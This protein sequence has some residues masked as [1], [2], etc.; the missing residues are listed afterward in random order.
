MIVLPRFAALFASSGSTLPTSTALVLGLSNALR[1]N[2]TVVVLAVVVVAAI[3]AW[4]AT[5]PDA[6][7][8][9]SRI[10]ISTPIVSPFYR[11]VLAARAARVI[12]ILLGGGAPL[13]QALDDA[14][15]SLDDPSARQEILRVRSRVREG[16]SAAAAFAEGTLFPDVLS[17]LIA[18]GEESSQLEAFFTKAADLFEERAKRSA[19]RFVAL[20]EPALIVAFGIVVGFIALAL[21]QA[22]Y[23]INIAP[24]RGR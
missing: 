19:A 18:A 20:A 16:S 9:R 12:S 7:E 21:V 24:V 4:L 14:S 2:A 23:G 10:L 11:E 3:V 17:R 22:I 15:R 1:A 6:A 13:M 5:S 8:T